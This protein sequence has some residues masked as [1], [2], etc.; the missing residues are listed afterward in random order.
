M[1]NNSIFNKWDSLNKSMI[2]LY[3]L[4]ILEFSDYL[5]EIGYLKTEKNVYFYL[6]SSEPYN[7]ES[8]LSTINKNISSNYCNMID[9]NCIFRLLLSEIY[10]Q[11]K[12][13]H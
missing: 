13:L 9:S 3:D 7:I 11:S 1:K 2:K 8:F 5:N 4:N 6:K 10:T 12:F